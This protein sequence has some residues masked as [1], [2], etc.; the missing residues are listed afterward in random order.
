[1]PCLTQLSR[2]TSIKTAAGI[3][4]RGTKVTRN[5]LI[6][7]LGITF[8]LALAK[9]QIDTPR[10]PPGQ[11]LSD[12]YARAAASRFVVIGTVVSTQGVSRRMT[13]ELLQHVKAEGELSLALG[14]SLYTI[15]VESTV[16][17][18]LDFRADASTSSEAPQTVY[19]FLPRE[20]PMFVNGHEREVL[21]P[22]QR[23]LLFL[24]AVPPQVQQKW[25][26]SFQLD[27]SQ[28]YYRGEGLSRGVVPLFQP[29][30][31][32]VTPTQPPV[33]E[34]VIQLCRAVRPPSVKE[35]LAALKMLASSGDPVLREEAEAA[36]NVLRAQPTPKE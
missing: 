5:L 4:R 17:R 32:V 18:Q 24:A 26:E 31:E 19:V 13:P 25:V 7:F 34:K 12:L 27:S 22:G 33:V 15:H 21:L 23:Y 8:S 6:C 28:G 2:S 11:D 9:P 10:T 14:G 16:C 35:K 29:T 20:E 30:G 36:A 3:K 1:M